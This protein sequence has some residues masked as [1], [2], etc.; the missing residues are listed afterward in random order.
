MTPLDRIDRQI[1]H[2]LQADNRIAN[3]A[4]AEKVGL[5]PAACSRRVARLRK[6]GI[7]VRDVSIIDPTLIG[8]AVKVIVAATL[9]Q[10]QARLMEAFKQ[11]MLARPE[12]VQCYQTAGPI[13]FYVVAVLADVAAYSDFAVEVFAGDDNIGSYESWFVLE[14]VKNETR[15]PFLAGAPEG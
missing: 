12:V 7:I 5:S 2:I 11:K 9:A 3:I 13:D 6:D 8:P 14:H 4:L 1:L 15:C 10:R